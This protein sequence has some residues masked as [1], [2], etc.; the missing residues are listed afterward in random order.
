MTIVCNWM[1]ATTVLWRRP[2]NP[3]QWFL[4]PLTH[5]VKQVSF[6]CFISSHCHWQMRHIQTE[7]CSWY[8][9]EKFANSTMVWM[10]NE[11]NCIF[12]AV[13]MHICCFMFQKWH[14]FSA[15]S[16]IL[17]FNDWQK[18]CFYWDTLS[19]TILLVYS[20]TNKLV[21]LSNIK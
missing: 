4:L 5:S 21:W 9:L 6:C 14:W 1:Y 11:K 17:C 16:M 7:I 20:C 10:K 19:V 8:H 15:K 3:K 2:L 18:M 12:V 13:R